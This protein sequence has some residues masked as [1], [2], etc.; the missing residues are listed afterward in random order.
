MKT[1]P[2]I[3]GA[4]FLCQAIAHTRIMDQVLDKK[5]PT[6]KN[7]VTILFVELGGG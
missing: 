1:R 3:F 7:R 6:G 2:D 4:G 5:M